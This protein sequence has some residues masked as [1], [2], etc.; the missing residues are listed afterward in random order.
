MAVKSQRT[1]VDTRAG[2]GHSH[3]SESI[4]TR[5]HSKV[6]HTG[7]NNQGKSTTRNVFIRLGRG[8]DMRETLNRRTEQEHSQHSTAQKVRTKANS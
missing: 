4:R 8:A 1:G 6:V 3:F 2:A 7:N 5:G